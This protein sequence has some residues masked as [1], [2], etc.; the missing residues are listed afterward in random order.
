MLNKNIILLGIVLSAVILAAAVSTNATSSAEL[1]LEK[2]SVWEYRS[3]VVAD[4]DNDGEN[5]VLVGGFTRWETTGNGC[6]VVKYDWGNCYGQG[7]CPTWKAGIPI[8][9]SR[10]VTIAVGDLDLDPD[11]ELVIANAT[12]HDI[13][14]DGRLTIW[15]HTGGDDFDSCWSMTVGEGI[16]DLAIGDCDHDGENELVVAYSYYWRGIKIYE[17]VGECEYEVSH[18]IPNGKDN[19]SVTIADC[20]N[21]DSL[22]I[23]ITPSVWG[24]E[25]CVWEYR[26]GTY[27]KVWCDSLD[28]GPPYTL[29]ARG[30]VGD[31]DNDG[32]NEI[33]VTTCQNGDESARGIY[34]FEHTVGDTYELDWS[35]TGPDKGSSDPFIADIL[36]DGDNEFL[37]VQY[38]QLLV[39]SYTDSGY[40]TLLIKQLPDT[41]SGHAFNRVYV[42]DSD[43]DGKNEV[44][45]SGNTLQAYEG[46]GPICGDANGDG[47]INSADV[48]YL[49]NYLFKNGPAPVPFWAGNCNCDGVVNS[50]D[51]VYLI[52]YLF[53]GGPAPCECKAT[54]SSG[55]GLELYKGKALAKIGFSS[56]TISK[57]GIYNVPIIGEFDVD[58]AAVELEIKYDPE[59]I[60]LL[61]PV[62]TSR[63]EGLQIYSSRKDGIQKIGILDISG[64]HYVSAGAGALVNL[65]LKGLDLS[66]RF[67]SLTTSLEITKAILVDPDAHQIPVKIVFEMKKSEK[68]FTG[69]KSAIPQDLSLSQNYP[70]PFNPET[71]IS[72]S[73][74]EHSQVRLT[75]YNLRGQKVR[76]LVDEYQTAG[77]KTVHW[78]GTDEEG[79]KVSSGV[80][81][82]R[83]KAGEYTET[84]KMILMK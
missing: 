55:S 15:D 83:I 33:L 2:E 10:D 22:E 31:A 58:V 14:S 68:D 70:N 75:I 47:I 56:P 44:V 4:V 61:E 39:Y 38:D 43:N 72:Y 81:L 12:P 76:V 21:D 36:N 78:D 60:T 45:I 16:A 59:E 64:E 50:A 79:N 66:S 20:D 57:N 82:Y 27:Q 19:H 7:Y 6:E 52:N 46:S 73:L 3:P 5:E 34:I 69:E 13:N 24:T 77:Q 18:S 23:V 65:R 1:V 54:T 71:E 32:D 9:Q 51:V 62:L 26:E 53:K 41:V 63:T 49:I 25:V 8:E 28:V 37:V 42:G 40:D 84:K 30:T 11:N 17:R 29:S 48:V 80:Y 74:P 35:D 67:A